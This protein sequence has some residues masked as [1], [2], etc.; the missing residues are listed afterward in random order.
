MKNKSP[1]N[2]VPFWSRNIEELITQLQGDT[3]KGLDSNEAEKRL[4]SIGKNTISKELFSSDFLLLIN[5]F[6]S[7]FMVLL[8]VADGLSFFLGQHV[9]AIIIFCIILLSAFLSFW[10]ERG[11]QEIVKSLLSM[12][13]ITTK[14]LRNGETKSIDLED[15]V[16]GDVVILAAGDVIPADGVLIDSHDFFVNEAMLTGEPYPEEKV[17]GSVPAETILKDRKN[18]LFKGTHV[19][20]GYARCLVVHTGKNTEFG[21]IAERIKPLKE[22][23]E[24]ERGLRRFGHLLIEIALVMALI[25]FAVNVYFHKDFIDSLLFALTLAI[26]VTPFLLPAIVSINL[27]YGARH[28]ASRKVV[29]KRL[30]SIENFGSMNV[31]CSDKT[32]TLTSGTIEVLDYI[33]AN[34]LKINRILDLA[35]FNASLQSGY[36]NPIDAAIQTAHKIGDTTVE[37]LDE[38]PFDFNRKRLSILAKIEGS[39]LMITKGTYKKIVEICEFVEVDD[40]KESLSGYRKKLDKIFDESTKKGLRIIAIAYKEMDEKTIQR[41]SEDQMVFAGMLLLNDPMKEGVLSSVQ[42]MTKKGLRLKILTGDNKNV[43]KYVGKQLEIDQRKVITGSELN[44]LDDNALLK[45][46]NAVH[47][48]AELE[49]SQKERIVRLLSKAGNVVGYIGDGINDVPA[50]QAADVGISVENAVDMAKHTADFILLEKDLNVLLNGILE[51]RRTF[52]NTIKYIFMTSSANFGNI[53]SMALI[54]LFL[55]FLPLLPKQILAT[56]FISDLPAMT[57]PGDHIDED[58]KILPKKWNLHFI[59]KFMIRFGLLSSVFDFVT[60][61]V[62]LFIVRSDIPHFR[63]GWFMVTILTEFVVLWVL[64]TQKPFYRSQPGKLLLY[65]TSFMFLLGLAIPYTF[66]GKILELPPLELKTM[67]WLL[68]VV[69]LYGLANELLKRFF[70]RKNHF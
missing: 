35:Y 58:W 63:A 33:N 6:R 50:L 65:S 61:G 64:R 32:G 51:G 60:F 13:K 23:T 25:I 68:F 54:S 17:S 15:L 14:V 34:N 5:Q 56:N 2:E 19:S 59:K 16:P 1:D 37:K 62:L 38:I 46:V 70:Y 31:F 48:F 3:K 39:I 12:V 27:A 4:R 29:V 44:R 30:V 11:A 24:F 53:V 66:L 57:I 52:V 42:E 69:L 41:E 36:V 7:P 40:K 9:D 45:K 47:I 43:A 20:S 49:P 21:R 55:P 10:Q 28:M 18:T 8:L 26:G 67:L 22:E